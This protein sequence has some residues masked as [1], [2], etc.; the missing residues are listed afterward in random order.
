M[1]VR[2][3]RMVPSGVNNAFTMPVLLS[4]WGK[5]ENKDQVK[6]QLGRHGYKLGPPG[7]RTKD[8][9]SHTYQPSYYAAPH[10]GHRNHTFQYLSICMC[11]CATC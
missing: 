2:S 10:K 8:S 11:V 6:G 3:D 4:F 5:E 7:D 9:F 1:L